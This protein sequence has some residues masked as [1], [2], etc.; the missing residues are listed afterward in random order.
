MKGKVLAV[1]ISDKKGVVKT[2]IEEGFFIEEFGLEG[3]VSSRCSGAKKLES[4]N[5]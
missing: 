5:A 4:S 2:P 3:D 1:N